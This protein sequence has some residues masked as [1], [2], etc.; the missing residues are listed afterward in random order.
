M[1]DE[2]IYRIIDRLQLAEDYDELRQVVEY[3]TAAIEND[4]EKVEDEKY[5][6][7]DELVPLKCNVMNLVIQGV[8]GGGGKEDER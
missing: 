1:E 2:R 6:E 7:A 8:S 4:G 5:T 3:A